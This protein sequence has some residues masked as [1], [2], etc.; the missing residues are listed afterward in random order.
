MEATGCGRLFNRGVKMS[1]NV[2]MPQ[3]GES[4]A[5]GTVARW[6]KKVGDAVDRD[7]P[8]FEI[9][10]D[11]VDAE[12]PSPGAGVLTEI[13]V[14]EGETVPVNSVVAVIGEAGARAEAQPAAA[15]ESA[16]APPSAMPEAAAGQPESAPAVA[17][18]AEGRA[19]LQ[20]RTPARSS[21]PAAPPGSALTK[22]ELRRQKSSP[23]VRR[24]ARE[25]NVDIRQINGTG[26]SGRVTKNDI[27]GF[28][29]SGK[30]GRPFD[31]AQGKRAAGPAYGPGDRVEIVPMTIMR[32]KIA[33]HMVLSAHTSPHVYSVYEVNFG[34]LSQLRERKKAEYERAGGKLS[35]TAL[36]AKVVV[37]ALRAFPI[38]NASIDGDNIVYKKDINLG[39]AV[40]L[41][42]GLIVPV[43]RNADEKNLL[44]LCRAIE[45]L[46]SRAR[47]K[48]LS[49]DEV[50]GGT[51]TITNPGIF[52][53]VYGLPL[54]NQPQVAILGVGGI[55]KRAVVVDD[56]IAIRPTCHLSL[57]YDHRL[58]DG[59]DAGRFLSFIKERLE[60]FDE[61]W[62]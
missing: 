6:I 42:Q 18:T 15:T 43:I 26:I 61:A 21:A 12:I 46:A 32:R 29:E 16:T 20:P 49:P 57:G 14:K 30:E 55:E 39:I 54:I 31:R 7:E 47:S 33:E 44:G 5:E 9:S 34:R 59:A 4:H 48:R 28:L 37:D 27:L 38:A 52:G 3:M 19:G 62:M 2:V 56:A 51:F 60:Q 45:D 22:E 17:A 40:A 41:E 8:L 1:T 53:A 35:F 13:K 58:I 11:K 25:H 10:T 50:Q 36:I 23:L 24:I